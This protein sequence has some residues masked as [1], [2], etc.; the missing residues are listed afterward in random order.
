MRDAKSY[1]CKWKPKQTGSSSTY[2]SDVLGFEPKMV[3][4]DKEGH[5]IMIKRSICQE[6]ATIINKYSPNIRHLYILIK[7]RYEGRNRQ[8]YGNCRGLPYPTFSNG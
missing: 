3:T 5:Y 6:G 1:L 4:R 8:Q 7:Y 2:T